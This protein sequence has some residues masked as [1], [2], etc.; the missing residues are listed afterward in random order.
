MIP[1]GLSNVTFNL[2][3]MGPHFSNDITAEGDFV[4]SDTEMLKM[5]FTG[6]AELC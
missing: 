3:G 2:A 5:A 4:L 1:S 6:D